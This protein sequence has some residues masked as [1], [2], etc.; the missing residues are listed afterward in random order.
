VADEAQE[1]SAIVR[2]H[3]SDLDISPEDDGQANCPLRKCDAGPGVACGEKAQCTRG[4]C[5]CHVGFKSDGMAF[6]GAE[7]LG[8]VTVYVDAGVACDVPCDSFSCKEVIQVTG[9]YKSDDEG[10]EWVNGEGEWDGTLQ[11]D[12]GS[13]GAINLPGADERETS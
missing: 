7:D 1:P 2:P 5:T 3:T 8:E 6:R 4:F 12:G 13:F 10:G 11:V 9:C